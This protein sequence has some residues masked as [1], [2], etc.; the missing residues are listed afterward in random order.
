M[1]DKNRRKKPESMAWKRIKAEASGL[2]S[3]MTGGFGGLRMKDVEDRQKRTKEIR[4][5]TK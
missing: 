3:A 1:S 4:R 2:A 5:R